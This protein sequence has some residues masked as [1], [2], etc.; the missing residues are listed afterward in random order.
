MFGQP[1]IATLTLV[2]ATFWF[3]ADQQGQRAFREGQ[4]R[5]AADHFSDPMWK[6][7]ALYRAGE[8]KEAQAVFARLDDAEAHYNRGN[9]LVFLGKYEDAMASYDRALARRP[10][11]RE[12]EENRA[13]AKARA[14]RTKQ[15]GGDLGDQKLGADEIKFD[16]K[17]PGGQETQVSGDQSGDPKSTQALWLRRVRTKPAD[18]LKAKFAYQLETGEEDAE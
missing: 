9:C 8:F 16:K 11:W 13:I 14:E 4:Y 7:T 15:E 3:T 12:A 10:G 6:G 17:K 18:F 2:A 5:E 1:L